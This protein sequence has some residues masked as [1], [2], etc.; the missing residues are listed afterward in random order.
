MRLA[1]ALN[2][3]CVHSE[4]KNAICLVVS[5]LMKAFRIKSSMWFEATCMVSNCLP[6]HDKSSGRIEKSS[7][8]STGSDG[9]KYVSAE[10]NSLMNVSTAETTHSS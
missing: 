4:L 10:G 2:H 1:G 7:L 5:V 9:Y 3:G 6:F 8:E